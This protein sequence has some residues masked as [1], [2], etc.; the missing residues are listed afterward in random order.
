[1]SEQIKI[2]VKFTVNTEYGEY[3]GVVYFTEDEWKNITREQLQEIKQDRANNWVSSVRITRNSQ[4]KEQSKEEIQ[5][6]VSQIDTNIQ[7]LINK[8]VELEE[9][10]KDI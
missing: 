7:E 10:I 9:K 1:M 5:L 4:P 2:Q 8:K 3:N 6:E